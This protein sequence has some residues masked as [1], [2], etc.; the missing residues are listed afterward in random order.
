[1]PEI[2]V[3]L[4][5]EYFKWRAQE[6]EAKNGTDDAAEEDASV[7]RKKERRFLFGKR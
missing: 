1:M 3:D 5:A 2:K 4:D 6:Q 7:V